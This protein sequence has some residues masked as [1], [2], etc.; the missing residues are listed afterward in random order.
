MGVMD[1]LYIKRTCPN[2]IKEFYPGDCDIVSS[3]DINRVLVAAPKSGW[4][5]QYS[6]H[7]STTN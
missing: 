7:Q 6:A 3:S 5:Q 1:H 2:C 4:K